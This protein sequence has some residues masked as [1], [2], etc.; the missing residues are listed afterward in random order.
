MGI[1]IHMLTKDK[2]RFYNEPKQKNGAEQR[3]PTILSRFIQPYRLYFLRI[4]NWIFV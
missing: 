1:V 4:K 2:F 3:F